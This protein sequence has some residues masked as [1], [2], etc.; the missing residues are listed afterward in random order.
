MTEKHRSKFETYVISALRRNKKIQVEYEPEKWP[1]V[2]PASTHQYTPDV[3]IILPSGAVIY[4]EL[5]GK[6][7]G[8][9]RKKMILVREQHPDKDLRI[10]FMRNNTLSKTSKTRYMDWATKAGYVCA[11]GTIPSSWLKE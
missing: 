11:V 3:K 6:L 9:T 4:V 8:A 2:M 10:V 5:K 7:D 1:Y